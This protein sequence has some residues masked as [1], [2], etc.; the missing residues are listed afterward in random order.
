MNLKHSSD[1]HHIAWRAADDADHL[2]WHEHVQSLG[3]RMTDVKDRNYFNAIYFR[4]FGHILFELATDPPGFA[5]DEQHET[6]G[7]QLMLPPQYEEHR[8]QLE[9]DLPVITITCHEVK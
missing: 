6:M 3:Y 8:T 7:E 5:H 2:E 1:I 9:H 4:E